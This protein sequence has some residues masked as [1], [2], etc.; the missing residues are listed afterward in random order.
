MEALL[1]GKGTTSMA[2][3]TS[4]LYEV[5]YGIVGED[6]KPIQPEVPNCAID[7]VL[8]YNITV[9]ELQPPIA[10]ICARLT[11]PSLLRLLRQYSMSG[12]NNGASELVTG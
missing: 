7:T 9:F 1:S 6:R 10:Q 4:V 11:L 5:Q 2:N 8:R 12:L 3:N